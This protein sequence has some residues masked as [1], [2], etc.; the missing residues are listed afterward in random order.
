MLFSL[1]TRVPRSR[2]L[3]FSYLIHVISK[4]VL[5]NPDI[6]VARS[7]FL[8]SIGSKLRA[9]SRKTESVTKPNY[10]KKRGVKIWSLLKVVI[11]PAVFRESQLHALFLLAPL[12]LCRLA[13]FFL[14]RCRCFFEGH[15]DF[16][17]GLYC[18]FQILFIFGL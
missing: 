3:G 6:R 1:C 5:S 13:L 17:Q 18:F 15:F 11:V 4:D 8:L 16:I 2:I 7:F 14:F 9:L 10:C 12:F